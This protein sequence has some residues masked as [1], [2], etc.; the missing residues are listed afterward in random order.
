[1]ARTNP[2]PSAFP[3]Q[4]E[5]NAF[6]NHAK[7]GD[8]ALVTQYLD[9]FGVAIIDSRDSTQDTAL[10]WAA[11]TGQKHIVALLLERGADIDK[12]GM[13]DRTALAWAANGG[14]RE[15]VE[16]LLDKGANSEPKDKNGST[17]ADLAQN[18]GHAELAAFIRENGTQ[19]RKAAA[20]QAAKE[21]A[22]Q[23]GRELA[24]LRLDALKKSK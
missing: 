3:T 6:C 2:I 15:V 24:A 10:S 20:E 16:F 23:E 19:K 21:K 5:I 9:R 13:T 17:A 8:T 7:I 14:R 18:T 22:E 1:M 12:T 4:D 11:W